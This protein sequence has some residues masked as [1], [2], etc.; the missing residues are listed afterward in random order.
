[1]NERHKQVLELREQGITFRAIAKLMSIYY[2]RVYQ[3]YKIAKEK[4]PPA[5]QWELTDEQIAKAK[6]QPP[7]VINKIKME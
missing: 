3:I 2:G 1:M 4:L 6:L 5:D 7:L